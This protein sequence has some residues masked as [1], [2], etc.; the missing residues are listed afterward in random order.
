MKPNKHQREE[1]LA[2]TWEFVDTPDV[3]DLLAQAYSIILGDEF[4]GRLKT[5]EEKQLEA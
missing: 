5:E 3:D 2:I 4:N 1:P